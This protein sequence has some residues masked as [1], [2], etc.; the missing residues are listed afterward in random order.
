MKNSHTSLRRR[1][2]IQRTRFQC[3]MSV[4]SA[5]QMSSGVAGNSQRTFSIF[6][7]PGL[8]ECCLWSAT[9]ARGAG[10]AASG[11]GTS[12]RWKV[13]RAATAA[14]FYRGF[15]RASFQFCC[16]MWINRSKNWHLTKKI[17]IFTFFGSNFEF[18]GRIL[19]INVF[20]V[21]SLN[22][23]ILPASDS[24]SLSIFV[25]ICNI[26]LVFRAWS[27][28]FPL[29]VV[30]V[31]LF[32]ASSFSL[33]EASPSFSLLTML[34]RLE[35]FWGLTAATA[36]DALFGGKLL[37]ALAPPELLFC[38]FFTAC[39]GCGLAT[40]S[41]ESESELLSEDPELPEPPEPSEQLF[42]LAELSDFEGCWG[43][44]TKP[45]KIRQF[46]RER[47]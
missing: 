12:G 9:D 34:G 29:G 37:V 31:E 14:T 45:V 36:T 15:A 24:E 22:W 4:E 30:A 2:V 43:L 35:F 8:R 47:P 27:F 28:L 25:C 26:L 44:V 17:K 40:L 32:S 5:G 7:A 42:E 39:W 33:S 16:K 3:E 10:P 19:R 6:Y 23:N 38:F 46:L 18:Y 20:I 11:S 13:S 21:S 41:D 1:V